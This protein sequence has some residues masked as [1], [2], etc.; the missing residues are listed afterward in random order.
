MTSEKT[1]SSKL[2]EKTINNKS[3]A[4]EMPPS[5]FYIN[6]FPINFSVGGKY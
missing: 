1:I 6:H 3:K 2:S 4:S 5:C